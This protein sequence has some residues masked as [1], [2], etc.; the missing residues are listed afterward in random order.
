M[1]LWSPETGIVDWS[2]VTRSYGENFLKLGGK[3]HTNFPVVKFQQA[4]DE[5][6]YPVLVFD[7]QGKVQS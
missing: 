6:E 4:T 5:N 3:V 1:A 7:D 2:L